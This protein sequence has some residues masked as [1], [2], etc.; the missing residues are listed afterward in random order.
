MPQTDPTQC[1]DL[2]VLRES[3]NEPGIPLKE[4]MGSFP[5]SLGTSQMGLM[6]VAAWVAAL[7]TAQRVLTLAAHQSSA[8]SCHGTWHVRTQD[9]EASVNRGQVIHNGPGVPWMHHRSQG[10]VS[11]SRAISR[12]S[13]RGGRIFCVSAGCSASGIQ[14]QSANQRST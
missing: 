1:N 9:G 7:C 14:R 3:R 13:P 12:M 10:Q 8:V 6:N 4:T 5:H 2:L 11:A